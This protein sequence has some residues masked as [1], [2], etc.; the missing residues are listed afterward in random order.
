VSTKHLCRVALAG[1]TSFLSSQPTLAHHLMGSK[2]PD[3][4]AQGVLSGLGHPVGS[5]YLLP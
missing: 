3:T 4:F 2:T 5:V 1:T